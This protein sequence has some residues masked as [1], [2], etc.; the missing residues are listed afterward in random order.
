MQLTQEQIQKMKHALGILH[1]QKNREVIANKIYRPKLK[2]YRN[3]YQIDQCNDWDD[4]VE[5]GLAKK[6][7][8]FSLNFYL[9]TTEGIDYLQELGYRFEK[10]N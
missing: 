7:D 10:E 4:L 8:A 2:S 6:R 3:H 5:K 1:D 9:V